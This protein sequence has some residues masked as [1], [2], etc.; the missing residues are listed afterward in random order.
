MFASNEFP[1]DSFFYEL[2][3]VTIQKICIEPDSPEKNSYFYFVFN[4]IMFSL[5]VNTSRKLTVFKSD[6]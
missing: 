3:Q 5:S 4:L 1:H 2:I 6:K